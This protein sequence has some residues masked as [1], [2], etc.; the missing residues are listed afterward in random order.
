[1]VL[2]RITRKS[3]SIQNAIVNNLES[4]KIKINFHDSIKYFLE[5]EKKNFENLTSLPKI[6]TITSW[7]EKLR[8]S[9]YY[10]E[11]DQSFFLHRIKFIL[12]FLRQ[13]GRFIFG[14]EIN[15]KEIKT[16]I[17][18][19]SVGKEIQIEEIRHEVLKQIN[20]VKVPCQGWLVITLDQRCTTRISWRAKKLIWKYERAKIVKVL[21]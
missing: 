1:M 19:T 7:H 11:K 3:I 16:L 5:V 12:C 10:L 6:W 9:L 21:G 13:Y 2:A 14:L 18:I 4:P 17:S 15:W 8:N 20:L